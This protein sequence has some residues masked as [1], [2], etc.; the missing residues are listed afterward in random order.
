MDE[1]T[2][3]KSLNTRL[4]TFVCLVTEVQYSKRLLS[5]VL[6]AV[7]SGLALVLQKY[8]TYN[9]KLMS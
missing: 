7:E 1:N 6:M 8:L 4:I 2:E 9:V 3:V 5:T